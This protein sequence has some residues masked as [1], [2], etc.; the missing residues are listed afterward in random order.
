MILR[1][2]THS[3]LQLLPTAPGLCLLLPGPLVAPPETGGLPPEWAKS[4]PGL[5]LC[6]GC[7]PYLE[8]LL[9]G[10]GVAVTRPVDPVSSIPDGADVEADLAAGV[11]VENASG[12]R[13]AVKALKPN[14][15]A[16]IRAHG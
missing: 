3:D 15:L 13:F 8:R 1:K 14:H 5:I 10:R 16:L 7:D 2:L 9:N 12:R 11:L 4:A 6:T